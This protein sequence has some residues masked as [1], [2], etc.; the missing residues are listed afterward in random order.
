MVS[1]WQ[2]VAFNQDPDSDNQIHG[3]DLAQRYGFEGG[4]VPGVTISAYLAH[5]AVEAWGLEFLSRGRLHVTVTSPLY[6]GE[7]FTVVI[8]EQTPDSYRATLLRAGGTA[9]DGTVSAN[10]QA[11]LIQAPPAAPQRRGDPIVEDGFRGPDSSDAVWRTLQNSGCHAQRFRWRPEHMMGTYLLDRDLLPD[12]HRGA[13]ARANT[14]YVLWISNW[15]AAT[16]VSMNPWV[17]LQT[18]SQNFAPIP[19]DTRIVAEMAVTDVFE[20]RGHGFFDACVNLF[21]EDDDRCLTSI[22]L[23]AIHR[24]RGADSP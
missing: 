9:T 16:N 13:D 8:D 17:H 19:A 23:R 24:L 20:R 22:D 1:N 7:E 3:D 15:I 11:S 2:G 14:A 6:D 21:A 12:L 18:T 5:P 4:L 10:A